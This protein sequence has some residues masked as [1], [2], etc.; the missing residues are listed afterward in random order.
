[1]NIGRALK[2]YRENAG[3]MQGE[4][5]EKVGI[6]ES[7]YCKYEESDGMS[8]RIDLLGKIAGTLGIDIVDI[9]NKAEE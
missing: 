4:L 5:A 3:L 2:F 8:I 1:M 9:L 6:T 7:T